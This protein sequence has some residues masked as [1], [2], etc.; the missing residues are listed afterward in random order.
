MGN[1]SRQGLKDQIKLH[2]SIMLLSP[3]LRASGLEREDVLRRFLFIEGL[4]VF[5][6]GVYWL[7][8]AHLFNLLQEPLCSF[9]FL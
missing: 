3:I 7:E 1:Q 9:V 2:F 5:A 8:S 4:N 6:Q